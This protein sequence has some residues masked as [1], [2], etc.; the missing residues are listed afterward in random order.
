MVEIHCKQH[1]EYL[2]DCS[3]C[4]VAN[5]LQ[6]HD[7]IYSDN[8]RLVAD[9]GL[10]ES[11]QVEILEKLRAQGAAWVELVKKAVRLE[12]SL[13]DVIDLPAITPGFAIEAIRKIL[14]EEL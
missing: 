4:V 8:R 11:Q 9:L 6:L 7:Q 5:A 14:N 12:G 1:T 3:A 13:I 2:N 10:S